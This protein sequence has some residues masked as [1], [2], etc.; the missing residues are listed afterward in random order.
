MFKGLL[1]FSLRYLV[2]FVLP[3]HAAILYALGRDSQDSFLRLTILYRVPGE[4][5]FSGYWR[6]V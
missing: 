6:D 1:P 5:S 2:H 3:E 4:A